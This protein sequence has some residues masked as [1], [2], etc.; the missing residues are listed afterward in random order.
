MTLIA[1][2]QP[3]TLYLMKLEARPAYS[4]SSNFPVFLV[5]YVHVYTR[6]VAKCQSNKRGSSPHCTT[7]RAFV[8]IA[9]D[10]CTSQVR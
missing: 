5:T 10:A 9:I 2:P 8:L 1:V 3:V 7:N 4:L 6:S